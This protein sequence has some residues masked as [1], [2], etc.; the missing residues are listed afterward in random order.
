MALPSQLP[1]HFLA[2]LALSLSGCV[3]FL[4]T[5]GA[6]IKVFPGTFL[7]KNWDDASIP[8]LWAH[9]PLFLGM[10]MTILAAWEVGEIIAVFALKRFVPRITLHTV[11]VGGFPGSLYAR[12]QSRIFNAV[13]PEVN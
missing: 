11:F 2:E 8:E 4:L 3:L 5:L 12:W 9:L 6:W 10:L 13:I 7:R 1:R